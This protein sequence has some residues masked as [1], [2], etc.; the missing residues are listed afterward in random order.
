MRIPPDADVRYSTLSPNDNLI[1]DQ[2]KLKEFAEDNFKFDENG[3][4][5]YE[6]VENPV[7]KKEIARYEQFL[8]FPQCLLKNQGLFGKGLH[9]DE[10]IMKELSHVTASLGI[11][12]PTD[13]SRLRYVNHWAAN[14]GL[15][16][17]YHTSMML[18]RI[19]RGTMT[20]R[21]IL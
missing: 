7:G 2:S 19:Q 21:L 16:G 3:R 20:S 11:G 12:L 17:Q 10:A 14:Q 18:V 13:R 4:N 9:G 6:W 1:L 8:L 15:Y 5:L